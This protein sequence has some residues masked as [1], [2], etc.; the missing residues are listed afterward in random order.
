MGARHYVW[1]F[2]IWL[3]G[4]KFGPDDANPSAMPRRCPISPIRFERRSLRGVPGGGRNRKRRRGP[5]G[6]V[7]ITVF[8]CQCL[9]PRLQRKFAGCPAGHLRLCRPH[10]DQPEPMLGRIW[11]ALP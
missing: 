3:R 1:L 6:R 5:I 11:I 2:R 9:M 4:R 7:P 8:F 10:G